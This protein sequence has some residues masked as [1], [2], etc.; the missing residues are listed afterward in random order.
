MQTSED[1]AVVAATEVD[2]LVREG[3]TPRLFETASRVQR[4]FR[5]ATREGGGSALAFPDVPG[6]GLSV[7]KDRSP[8]LVF[9][10]MVC[11]VS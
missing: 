11:E 4:A 5:S 8:A 9:V 7:E 2:E 1:A 3:I 6:G 10:R